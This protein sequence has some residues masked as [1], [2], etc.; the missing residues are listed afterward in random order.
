M[1]IIQTKFLLINVGPDVH[2]THGAPWFQSHKF[3]YTNYTVIIKVAT[4]GPQLK[5]PC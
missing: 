2:E 4:R 3:F 1:F 5:F